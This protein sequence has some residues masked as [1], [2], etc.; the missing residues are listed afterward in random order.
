MNDIKISVIVPLYNGADTL[1]RC[2]RSIVEQTMWESMELIL[3]DDGSTDGSAELADDFADKH[4][5]VTAV[6]I[7]NGGVSNARNVGIQRAK[8]DYIGFVD[9]DDWVDTDSYERLFAAGEDGQADVIG[10]GF[11]IETAT[12]TMLAQPAADTAESLDREEAVK[13]FLLGKFDVHVWTKIFK[14]TSLPDGLFDTAIAIAEDRLFLFETLLNSVD[15]RLLP[16]CFYHYFMNE[17]SAVHQRFSTKN[18]GDIMASE[19]M[20][21]QTEKH[22]PHFSPYA[23]CMDINAKCRVLTKLAAADN[24]ADFAEEH[25]DLKRE[26]RR[27]SLLHAWKYAGKKQF[28]TLLLTKISPRLVERLKGNLALK[29]KR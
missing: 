7:P 5:R 27:F 1:P 20:V 28:V 4:A 15:I 17:N 3:V 29:Y 6:H 9:A 13:R 12:G 23:A 11:S 16:F 19:R 25:R 18:F 2:V 26:V 14:R 21:Q 24:A 22:L 10:A 8:G